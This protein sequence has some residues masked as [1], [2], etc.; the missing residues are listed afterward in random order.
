MSGQVSENDLGIVLLQAMLAAKNIRPQ[1]DRLVQLRRR[2][3]QLSLGEDHADRI[4]EL[5]RDLF[6]VY[7]IG[8]EYGARVL[9]TCLKLAVQ[10]GARFSVNLA[11]RSLVQ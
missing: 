7:F 6:D 8:I 10:H 9:A 2:L 3:E 4:K 1:R 5:A 11:V